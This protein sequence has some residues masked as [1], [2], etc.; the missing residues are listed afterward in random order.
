MSV[1]PAVCEDR[2]LFDAWHPIAAVADIAPATT[3][4]TLL[5]GEPLRYGLD[6]CAGLWASTTERTGVKPSR[7]VN[8]VFE[9]L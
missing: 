4:T 6:E 5:L 8:F 7:C 3:F 2:A 9:H 1:S